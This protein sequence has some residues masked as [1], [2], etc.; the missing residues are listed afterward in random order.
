MKN[1][2]KNIG[3]SIIIVIIAS[4][5]GLLAMVVVY[6]IPVS[7]IS[8][9]ISESEGTLRFQVEQSSDFVNNTSNILDTGTNIIMLHESLY[10]L[11]GNSINDALLN[12]TV[13]DYLAEGNVWVDKI[14]YLANTGEFD[15]SGKYFY[16]RYW[17]GYL[18]YLK[19]LLSFFDLSEI[20]RFNFIIV[21]GSII[22]VWYLAYKKLGN[23]SFAY[24]M[25]LAT[26]NVGSIYQ[27][28]QLS[29][30]FYTMQLT[31]IL[32]LIQKKEKIEKNAWCI[33]LIDGIVLAYIDFLTYPVLTFTVPIV[34]Y[35]LLKKEKKL[36]LIF[37]EL[38]KKGVF[39]VIGY[40]GMWLMKWIYATLLTD[41]NVIMDAI[42]SV[43]HRVGAGNMQDED[44]FA[45]TRSIAITWNIST[46]FSPVNIVIIIL[47]IIIGIALII[48]RRKLYFHKEVALISVI[49]IILPLLWI[50]FVY[51]HCAQHPHLEWRSI[52]GI[53][54]SLCVFAISLFEDKKNRYVED[55]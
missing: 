23:Y 28:F 27:S 3:K 35:L 20:Y 13:D 34:I 36:N 42:Q 8:N 40:V 4:I 9:H 11:S 16:P 30:A 15:K 49:G 25:M 38:I 2:V 41:E 19:P 50:F 1:F 43:L 17:H 46:F 18:T 6:N 37:I 10:P 55:R 5:V 44:I 31:L 33:F 47:L 22:A 12:P 26:M 54:F 21:V 53:I 29:S 52:C 14:C 51:N 24:L 45:T 32:L 48:I 39:F 7:R